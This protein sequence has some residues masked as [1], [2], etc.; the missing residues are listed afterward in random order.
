MNLIDIIIGVILILGFYKGFKKGFVLELTALLGLILGITGAFYLSKAHGLY[1]G[2]WLDWDDEYLR[3]TTFLLSFIVIV[4]I[5]SLIGKLITKLIDFVALSFINKLL[6]GLFGLLKFGLLLSILLLLFNVINEQ[7]EMVSEETL[8]ES[9]SYP[10]LNQFTD[11]IWPKL[12]EMS[13]EQKEMLDKL[14]NISE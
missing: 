12:V 9:I 5:V 4:I 1:I 8:N 7:V 14:P 11:I 6:G 3:I 10:I 2:Q 13:Q